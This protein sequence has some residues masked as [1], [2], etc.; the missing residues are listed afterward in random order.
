MLWLNFGNVKEGRQK[1]FQSWTKK[2]EN[3]IQKHA[4]SGWVYRGTFGTVLG[5]GRYDTATIWEISNYRDF[6]TLRDHDDETFERLMED[7]QEFFLP[8]ASEAV[9]LREIGDVK[10]T[11]PKKP[12]K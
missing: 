7:W 6:D 3:M 1:D 9:L 12:K 2:N 11:E 10:I 5:F 4:P 8:G